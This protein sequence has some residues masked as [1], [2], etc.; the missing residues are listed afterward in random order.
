[1]IASSGSISLVIDALFTFPSRYSS[2]SLN[3]HTQPLRMVPQSSCKFSLTLLDINDTIYNIQGYHLLRITYSKAFCCNISQQANPVSLT[4]TSEVS[5]DFLSYSYLDV[6]VCCVLYIWFTLGSLQISVIL[7]LLVLPP[8]F[9]EC[10]LGIP[11]NHFDY[12][13]LMSILCYAFI[14]NRV[15]KYLNTLETK[16]I[17]HLKVSKEVFITL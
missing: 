8:P 7:Q 10:S 16:L 9:N 2:L 12:L 3:I 11:N 1:M 13:H 5:V 17:S 15:F 14:L 6:S 4:T